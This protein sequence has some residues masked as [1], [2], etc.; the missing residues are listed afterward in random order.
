VASFGD[1]TSREGARSTFLPLLSGAFPR[2]F[3]GVE[4]L[5]ARLIAA[6]G[7]AQLQGGPHLSRARDAEL[8]NG[9]S[10]LTG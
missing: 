7:A 8:A 1:E 10:T 5:P 4:R 2:G 6:A 9:Q 3:F